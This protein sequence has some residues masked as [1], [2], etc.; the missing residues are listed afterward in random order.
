M[1]WTIVLLILTFASQ[2]S[3]ASNY[4][5]YPEPGNFKTTNSD[6]EFSRQMAGI[7][8]K[9]EE[10]R[11]ALESSRQQSTQLRTY[12]FGYNS[13]TKEIFYDGQSE[14]LTEDVAE[15]ALD[16]PPKTQEMLSDH[17]LF[18]RGFLPLERNQLQAWLNRAREQRQHQRDLWIAG[19]IGLLLVL[20]AL[21][22]AKREL[23]RHVS[24][25]RSRVDKEAAAKGSIV[26][27]LTITVLYRLAWVAVPFAI[28]YWLWVHR[29]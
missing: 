21:R 10:T 11:A 8:R 7:Q 5:A 2:P 14:L 15:Q 25:L 27:I 9:A 18:L 4:Q 22:W 26:V 17:E 13:D 23:P 12:P 20:L 16:L 19:S 28:L 3:I 29:H 6:A 24:Y 1:G